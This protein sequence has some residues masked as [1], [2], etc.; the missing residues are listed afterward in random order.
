MLEFLELGDAMPIG[1]PGV[2]RSRADALMPEVVLDELERSSRV[3]QVR[4]DRMTQRVRSEKAGQPRGNPVADEKGLNLTLLK[5]AA[6]P[7]KEWRLRIRGSLA[8]LRREERLAGS[9][10]WTLRPVST[11]QAL[12]DEAA[13]SKVEVLAL[14]QSDFADAQAILV[15][16]GEECPVACVMNDC[17]KRFKLWL[18]EVARKAKLWRRRRQRVGIEATRPL[19]TARFSRRAQWL[20]VNV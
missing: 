14:E 20:G 4:R 3:E 10:Q 2:N 17:E 5:G 1:H 15:Y 6:P 19:A 16:Q 12:D 18:R 13:A 11:L 7:R 8:Q 9:K